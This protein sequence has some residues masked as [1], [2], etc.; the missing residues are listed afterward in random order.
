MVEEH[1]KEM[2]EIN[3]NEVTEKIEIV[4]L[5]SYVRYLDLIRKIWFVNLYVFFQI[6]LMSHRKSQ[7]IMKITGNDIWKGNFYIVSRSQLGLDDK[8]KS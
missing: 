2:T 5:I 4:P 8:D 7:S 3:L 1:F 6:L